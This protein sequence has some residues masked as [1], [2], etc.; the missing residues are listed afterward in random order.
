MYTVDETRNRSGA[1]IFIV[2]AFITV[3]VLLLLGFLLWHFILN[4]DDATITSFEKKGDVTAVAAVA[5][6]DFT[7]DTFSITLPD[8]WEFLGKQHPRI[9]ETYF[10]Y[11][12][13]VKDYENRWLNVYVDVFPTDYQLNRAMIVAVEGDKLL[14]G[15]I[16]DNCRKFDGA[17]ESGTLTG[18]RAWSATWNDVSFTCNISSAVNHIGTVTDTGYGAEVIGATSGAHKYFFVYIDHN[19][20]PDQSILKNA[21]KSFK[22]I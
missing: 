16:S 1:K 18:A 5:T 4:S 21:V 6:K 14:P 10:S 9:D 20:H 7:T 2:F 22:A 11:K 12:S 17:P 13:E 3:V 19:A 15:Q 8:G